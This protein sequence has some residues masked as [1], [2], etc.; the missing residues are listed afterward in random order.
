VNYSG[1]DD[2]D[3]VNVLVSIEDA[4]IAV[5]FLEQPGNCVKVSWRSRQG[6]DV[7]AVAVGFGGGGHPNASGAEI[8]G[9]LEDVQ[10]AVLRA[11]SPIL[12]AQQ[13]STHEPSMK[14]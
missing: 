5:I 14:E 3:L 12:G 2:A 8:P 1:R 7:S 13:P 9:D 4:D 11:T 6:L 10:K